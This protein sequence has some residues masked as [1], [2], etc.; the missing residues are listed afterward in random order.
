VGHGDQVTDMDDDPTTPLADA[1]W[2][3]VLFDQAWLPLARID[4]AGRILDGNA[5]FCQLLGRPLHELR[6]LTGGELLAPGDRQAM[7]EQWR[8]L[9]G[10]QR[11]RYRSRV[12]AVHKDRRLISAIATA[13]LVR[14]DGAAPSQA[15]CSLF[16]DADAPP[17]DLVPA[18]LRL[19]A[20]EAA[21]LEGLAR[22]LSNAELGERLHLSRQ[23]LDYQLV[24]LRRKLRAQS[25]CALVA[26]A[27]VLGVLALAVWPPR[28]EPWYRHQPAP[29]RRARRP[30]A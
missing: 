23:G 25:R 3:R 1:T 21:A 5:A 9:I 29:H 30:P 2:Y 28:V 8:R 22:G 13:W 10:G 7:R 18:G 17:G 24:Q 12:L 6:G 16:P 4:L 20:C 14:T 15:V 19:S 27:Y 11:T 26:R